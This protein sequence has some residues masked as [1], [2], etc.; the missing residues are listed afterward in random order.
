MMTTENNNTAIF[1]SSGGYIVPGKYEGVCFVYG[2]SQ[3]LQEGQNVEVPRRMFIPADKI[4][5]F[6]ILEKRIGS[7]VSYGAEIR[8]RA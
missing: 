7:M 4:I 2:G 6:K 1:A 5:K 3:R 8:F